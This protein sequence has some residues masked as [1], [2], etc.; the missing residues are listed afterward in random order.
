MD[1]ELLEVLRHIHNALD[2]LDDRVTELESK[3]G[4]QSDGI[5]YEL[6]NIG[7]VV[8]NWSQILK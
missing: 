2:K 7:N 5:R 4:I 8:E 6:S 3:N 1:E